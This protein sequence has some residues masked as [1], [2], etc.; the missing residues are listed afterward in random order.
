MKRYAAY[1]DLMHSYQYKRVMYFV[2]LNCMIPDV[3]NLSTCFPIE[4]SG[5]QVELNGFSHGLPKC[6]ETVLVG[7]E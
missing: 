4:S 6:V 7:S 3:T 1:G 2:F 5:G